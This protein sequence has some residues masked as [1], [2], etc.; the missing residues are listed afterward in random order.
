[1]TSCA[2][3]VSCAESV[4]TTSTKIPLEITSLTRSESHPFFLLSW[5]VPSDIPSKAPTLA[6]LPSNM[7]GAIS[8]LATS[9]LTLVA[10]NATATGAPT[11][12]AVPIAPFTNNFSTPHHF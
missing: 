1:M 8:G 2:I 3:A 6:P 12:T 4:S 11:P 7:S 9:K 10:T 5:A